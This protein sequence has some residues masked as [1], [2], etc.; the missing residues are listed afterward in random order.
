MPSIANK[1]KTLVRKKARELHEELSS[2]ALIKIMEEVRR[3]I[4]GGMSRPEAEKKVFGE[5]FR[6]YQK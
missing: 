6:K 5:F 4:D 3:L 2:H 1:R